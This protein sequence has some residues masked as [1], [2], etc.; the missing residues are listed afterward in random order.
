MKKSPFSFLLWCTRLENH[1]VYQSEGVSLRCVKSQLSWEDIL[2]WLKLNSMVKCEV[3]ISN[4][5]KHESLKRISFL[6]RKRTPKSKP[7]T[8]Q[9]L[10]KRFPL[11]MSSEF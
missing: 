4:G 2:D 8:I 5:P 10:N 9:F 3:E 6:K 1:F 11:L 7:S